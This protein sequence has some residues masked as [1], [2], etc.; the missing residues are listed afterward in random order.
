MA[1][2]TKNRK[3][4]LEL[5]K[6]EQSYSLNEAAGLVK[7][8]SSTKFDSSVDVAVRLGVDPRKANQMVRGV[9]SLPHGTGKTVRV[10]VLCTPERRR[11]PRQPVL[12]MLV[13]TSISTRSRA[14][15]P[16]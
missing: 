9:V 12:T 3:K 13:L 14:V 11:R 15:G 4:A 7:E 10:L 16:M 2:L 5:L 6:P 8:M 1:K